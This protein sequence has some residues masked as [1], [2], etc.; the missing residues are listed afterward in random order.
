M[1]VLVDNEQP[2]HQEII[3]VEPR[4]EQPDL[5]AQVIQK[6]EE[7]K[8]EETKLRINSAFKKGVN[9]LINVQRAAPTTVDKKQVSDD[10]NP[11]SETDQSQKD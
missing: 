5:E 7:R 10:D 11:V 3:E 6:D 8:A 9:K 1:P 4:Q 2:V